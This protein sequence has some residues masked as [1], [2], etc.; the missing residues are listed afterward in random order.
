[1]KAIQIP[2]TPRQLRLVLAKKLGIG[3]VLTGLL[4]GTVAYVWESHR[5]EQLAL[6]HATVGVRHFE[7]PAMQ[8]AAVKGSAADHSEIEQLLTNEFVG[9]RVFSPAREILFEQWRSVP[10]ALLA[11]AQNQPHP[12]PG[13]GSG[14]SKRIEV[15]GE[16][17]IQ[18]VIPMVAQDGSLAGYVEGITRLTPEAIRV[19]QQGIRSVSIATALSV[20][21][22][23]SLLYPLMLAM[24]RR[25]S[26]LSRRLLDA[27]L[28]LMHS[29]GNAIAKRDADTDAHNYRV[30]CYSVTLA[31]SLGVPSATI[32]ELVLGAFLHDIGKIGIPDQILLKPGRLTAEEFTVMQTHTVLGVEIVAGNP[33]LS[34]AAQTIRHHHEHY[35]GTGYPD[36]LAG[37]SIPLPARIFALADVF[38]ALTSIRPYKQ[39]FSLA[40]TLAIM[41]REAGKQFDPKFHATFSLLA[42]ALYEKGQFWSHAEWVRELDKVLG[43]YFKTEMAS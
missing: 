4:A 34:G 21:V 16:E 19:R 6:R 35:D 33:W 2:E 12:W 37:Q 24:L 25:S 42:P 29:L 26:A 15:A 3:A 27:N 13:A 40:D 39:A 30:T 41:E 23:A 38:D 43:R 5:T 22:A 31:E 7:S 10:D 18:V 17:L 9:I 1:M 8:V 11:A 32:A 28:S 20:L 36:G 14:H